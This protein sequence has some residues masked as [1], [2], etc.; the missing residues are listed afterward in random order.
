VPSTGQVQAHDT[1]VGAE[2]RRV[3]SEVGGAARVG[4]DVHAPPFRVQTVGLQGPVAAQVLDLV[5][6]LVTTV[7]AGA[8]EAFGVLKG[9]E[10]G[11]EGGKEG[12]DERMVTA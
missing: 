11:R 1:V 12:R 3:N 5:H 7:V 8:G 10:E 9:R 4:L 6:H 2:E